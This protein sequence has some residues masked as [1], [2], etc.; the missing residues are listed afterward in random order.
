MSVGSELLRFSERTM[1]YFDFETQRVQL[2]QDNLPFQVS[3]VEAV[4]NRTLSR[5]NYYLNWGPGFK[6]SADAARIT[7]FNPAWVTNGDDPAFVLDAFESH[8]L[9][10][11]CWLVGH[12]ILGFD[13]Y[14]WNLWRQT[15]GRGCLWDVKP[16]P[17][18]RVIDT[19]LLARAYKEGWK[20][21]RS[22]PEAFLAWQYKVLQGF[23]RGVKTNLTLMCKELGIEIDETK[24]HDATYDLF[25]NVQVG[26]ALINKMEI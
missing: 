23:R 8:A 19:N 24:T 7:R 26:W 20:P 13:V 9:D 4:K 5:A 25:L 16:N 18:L 12:S 6:M 21:D 1:L 11:K 10:P 2:Q 15:L 14:I 17:L 22:S 3:F